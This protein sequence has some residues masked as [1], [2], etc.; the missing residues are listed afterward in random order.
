MKQLYVTNRDKWRE[1]LGRH[2]ATESGVWLVFYKKETSK[3]TIAYEAAVEEALCF[4]WIDSI[5][6]KIDAEKYARKLT[7]RKDKS[8]WSELNK[9]RARK[10]IKEGRMADA[11]LAKVE[12]AKKSGLW[13]QTGRP[14]ISFDMPS[15]FTQALDKNNKAQENFEK[16]APSYRKHYIGWIQAAKRDETKK[17]RIR[18]SVLLL[19]QGK[20]LGLK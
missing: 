3:P 10:M 1:W 16:L 4:G 19:A 14:R 6:K 17:K 15:E 9:K 12:A 5:I 2:Y 11:G 20:R 7:P 8:Y 13:E 18:E